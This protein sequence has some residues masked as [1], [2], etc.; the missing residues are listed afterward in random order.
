MG[1]FGHRRDDEYTSGAWWEISSKSD[2]RWNRSG[3][4]RGT[5]DAAFRCEAAIM[6]LRKMLG[7][8]PADLEYS[9]GKP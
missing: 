2:P 7:E 9:G 3:S 5:W 4:A 8:P 6:E 1:I